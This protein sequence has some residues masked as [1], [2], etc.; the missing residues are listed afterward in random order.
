M[1]NIH[2]KETFLENRTQLLDNKSSTLNHF[3]C[4][5]IIIRCCRCCCSIVGF[6]QGLL[7]LAFLVSMLLKGGV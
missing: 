4:S 3:K 5:R 6:K 7:I 1:L 2:P